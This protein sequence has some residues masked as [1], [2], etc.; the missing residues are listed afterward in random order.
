VSER[1]TSILK[2]KQLKCRKKTNMQRIGRKEDERRKG[3]RRRGEGR[4]KEEGRK[5]K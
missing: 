1:A 4:E 3:G 2:Q 5:R